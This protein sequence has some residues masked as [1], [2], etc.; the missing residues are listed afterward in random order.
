LKQNVCDQGLDIYMTNY[1][2]HHVFFCL[3]KRED[4]AACC[5]DNG[6]EAAFDHMKARIKKL[7]LNGEDKVRI[8]LAQA[9]LTVVVKG[10]C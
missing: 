7:G 5:A 6:A 9:V 10:H 2:Q 8:N 1:Y 3:N 4:G